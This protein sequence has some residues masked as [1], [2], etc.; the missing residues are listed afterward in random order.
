MGKG[1]KFW[2]STKIIS[3]L[4][5]NILMTKM[6]F[7]VL[8]PENK[9]DLINYWECYSFGVELGSNYYGIETLSC[10]CNMQNQWKLSI[11]VFHIIIYH[12]LRHLLKVGWN[13]PLL[14]LIETLVHVNLIRLLTGSYKIIKFKHL[15]QW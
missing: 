12:C 4:Y 13:C 11:S 10:H 15:P 1:T 14:T 7:L 6:H 9:L 2:R 8:E 5:R 3:N